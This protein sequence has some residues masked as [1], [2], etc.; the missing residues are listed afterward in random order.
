MAQQ[1]LVSSFGPLRPTDSNF[2]AE[3]RSS[4][5]APPLFLSVIS[6][7][8]GAC[9]LSATFRHQALCLRALLGSRALRQRID[10]PFSLPGIDPSD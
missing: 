2:Q 7:L 9:H 1:D 4:F 3:A 5:R 10:S 8:P 6:P